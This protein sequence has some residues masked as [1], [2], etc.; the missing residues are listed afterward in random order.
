M[1]GMTQPEIIAF[2]TAIPA[3]N[4]RDRVAFRL[5]SDCGLR[6]GEI[7]GGE[8]KYKRNKEN[9]DGSI[10]V[11]NV[12]SSLPGLFSQDIDWKNQTTAITGKGNKQ[13]I[14]AIPGD[15][16]KDIGI[17]L[18]NS[19]ENV[20]I[21][22]TYDNKQ[23][24]DHN[25]RKIFHRYIK[26]AGITRKGLHPHDLR[27]TFGRSYMRDGGDLI[28]LQTVMGHASVSTT[29]IY[30]EL[31]PEEAAIKSK[32]IICKNDSICAF[33]KGSRKVQVTSSDGRQTV[34]INCPTC[35]DK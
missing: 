28:T 7:V 23:M 14:A 21:I 15:L 4:I 32:K 8:Y 10:V 17:I 6:I 9:P 24:S 19:Q 26:K 20:L 30:T 34:L 25:L 18:G 11:E 5:M 31:S 13:R 29:Q 3:E 12:I 2:F 33:C 35:S 27:H 16:L 1:R 22:R